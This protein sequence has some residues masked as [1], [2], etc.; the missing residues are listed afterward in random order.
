MK[1]CV[2]WMSFTSPVEGS[3]PA[4]QH[5]SSWTALC[6]A[7]AWVSVPTWQ[8]QGLVCLGG[9][10]PFFCHC[11]ADTDLQSPVRASVCALAVV[12]SHSKALEGDT[13][14]QKS[15]A[16]LLIYNP[17]S[18]RLLALFFFP[19]SLLGGSG[20][21]CDWL[22]SPYMPANMGG[23]REGSIAANAQ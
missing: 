18:F 15:H 21:R 8:L 2:S 7:E 5:H 9:C 11:H 14:I 17:E 12:R 16:Y 23:R 10:S 19:F 3:R 4:V 1:S 22:V 20:M 13:L 6:Q